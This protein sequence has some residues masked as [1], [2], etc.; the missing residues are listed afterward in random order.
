VFQA[1]LNPSQH[2]RRNSPKS[3]ATDFQ[4]EKW[5]TFWY[6][7]IN[8]F[9]LKCLC[10]CFTRLRSKTVFTQK[11]GT[12]ENGTVIGYT[13]S[14]LSNK[15]HEE[16]ASDR[17]LPGLKKSPGLPFAAE[18]LNFPITLTKRFHLNFGLTCLFGHGVF[19][20]QLRR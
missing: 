6:N 5:P 1:Q 9:R 8:K 10:K 4:L 16:T 18:H 13:N 11:H 20:C 2:V 3:G 7:S 17:R 19:Q 15:E 14:G 12:A